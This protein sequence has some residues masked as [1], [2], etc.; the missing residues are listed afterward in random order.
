VNAEVVQRLDADH[1]YLAYRATST[2]AG[3]YHPVWARPETD[4]ERLAFYAGVEWALRALNLLSE[5][6]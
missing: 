2:A 3:V 4:L 6:R 5:V 1:G